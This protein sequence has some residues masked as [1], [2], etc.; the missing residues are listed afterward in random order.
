MSSLKMFDINNENLK[1]DNLI[2]EEYMKNLNYKNFYYELLSIKEK[3]QKE[4]NSSL[5]TEIIQTEYYYTTSKERIENIARVTT[6]NDRKVA[7]IELIKIEGKGKEF[8][9]SLAEY[10]ILVKNLKDV[11]AF[12]NKEDKKVVKELLDK[13]F[14][15]LETAEDDLYIPLLFEI[16]KRHEN[17][18]HI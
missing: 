7:Q 11:F 9:T 10:L 15:S 16:E 8:I 17:G 5:E 13:G 14:I 2:L 1:K 6:I 18:R 12:V 4:K 3:M